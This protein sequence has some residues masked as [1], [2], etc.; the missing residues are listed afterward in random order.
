VFHCAPSHVAN[1][2]GG[3]LRHPNNRN[4][5]PRRNMMPP[6]NLCVAPEQSAQLNIL[7]HVLI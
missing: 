6:M 7:T 2:F 4:G 5:R 3:A 1:G